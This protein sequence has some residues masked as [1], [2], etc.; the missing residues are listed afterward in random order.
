MARQGKRGSL[1]GG[2]HVFRD[3]VRV[4]SILRFK[5]ASNARADKQ[6]TAP[7]VRFAFVLPWSAYGEH[8]A[9]I[10]SQVCEEILA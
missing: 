7:A 5:L 8:V 4:S 9:K 2:P 10:A 3:A 6:S 1:T